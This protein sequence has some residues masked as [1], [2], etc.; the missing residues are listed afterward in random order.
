[1][2]E[3][4]GLGAVHEWLRQKGGSVVAV[5]V[6][7]VAQARGVVAEQKLPFPVLSDSDRAVTR[8]YGLIDAGHDWVDADIAIPAQ[9]LV[10]SAGD[11]LWRHV[12]A[13]VQ[14]RLSPAAT[15]AAV[16]AALAAH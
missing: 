16:E 4:R 11:V 5:A 15:L 12:S 2:S 6:D 10:G 9:I 13:F 1:M 8:A 14:D 3:L 7:P